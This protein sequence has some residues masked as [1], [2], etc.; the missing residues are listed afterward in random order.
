MSDNTEL[1]ARI[2]KLETQLRNMNPS[3]PPPP[4]LRP[5]KVSYEPDSN[6]ETPERNSKDLDVKIEKADYFR[7]DPKT[8]KN[9]FGQL[10]MY[11]N[12]QPRR[13]SNDHKRIIYAGSLFWDWPASWW[14]SQY[15]AAVKPS[16]MYNWAEF[17]AEV[18]H[19]F[20]PTNRKKEAAKQLSPLKQTKSAAEHYTRFLEYSV[21]AGFNEESMVFT[22]R[23]GLK[24]KI[25]DAL[26]T[27][28]YEPD[29][30]VGL[31]ELC[32][33]LDQRLYERRMEGR[34]TSEVRTEHTVKTTQEHHQN[35][36][37]RS[38]TASVMNCSYLS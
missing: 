16:W 4:S 3:V 31:A 29:T 11:T 38:S 36:P 12:L 34:A 35:L 26:S 32:I 28:D 21:D 27:R 14:T 17:Q 37:A 13:Y 10:M 7:G 33:W 25:K 9:F 19:T 2:A 30:L 23:K 18:T 24:S 1:L 8:L 20:N 22:F 5:R 15:T 6:M